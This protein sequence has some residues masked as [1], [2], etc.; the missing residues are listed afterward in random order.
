[1]TSP[2]PEPRG[3]AG[4][5]ARGNP[6][7]GDTPPAEG[8]VSGISTPEPPELRH[9]WGTWPAWL[10]VLLCVAVSL[11]LIGVIIALAV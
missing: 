6:F 2:D 9:A 3:T 10:V 11:M 1:M 7:P 5:D 8:G 4:V